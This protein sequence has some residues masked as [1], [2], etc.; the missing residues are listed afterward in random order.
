MDD[1]AVARAAEVGGHLLG[2]LE[3]RVE[4]HRPGRRHVRKGLLAAPLVD[5]GDQV[6]DLFLDAVEVGH[7]VVHADHAAFGA[8]AVVAGDVEDQRVVHFTDL[9]DRIHKSADIVISVGDESGEH[10]SLAAEEFLVRFRQANPTRR[11]PSGAAAVACW[12]E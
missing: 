5:Q 6:L 2:P 1:H 10:L 12:R 7:F 8:R 9:L 11:D 3:R 4:G